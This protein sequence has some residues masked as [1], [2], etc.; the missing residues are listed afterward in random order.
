MKKIYLL[1]TLIF[2]C[3]LSIVCKPD[4]HTIL[5]VPTDGTII[6]MDSE[7]QPKSKVRQ[8]WFDLMHSAGPE[9]NWKFIET[10]NAI[11]QAKTKRALRSNY[12]QSSND[13]EGE[14]VANGR[15]EGIWRERG[16]NNQAGSM[17]AINYFMEEDMLFGRSAGGTLWKG[18][19]TGFNWEVVNQDFNFK[20]DLVEMRYNDQGT[21]RYIAGLNGQ[22]VY[23]DD[24]GNSWLASEIMETSASA[25]VFNFVEV[26]NGMMLI[27][28]KGHSI[29]D[30]TTYYSKDNGTTWQKSTIFDTANRDNIKIARVGNTNDIIA[31]EQINT[32]LTILYKWNH[33]TNTF[34]IINDGSDIGFGNNTKANISAVFVDD[35]I[36]M[37]VRNHEN[38][39]FISDD[40]GLT[41]QYSS[42]LLS[43]PWSVGF[44]VSPSDH[45]K[46]L[47]GDIELYRSIDEGS[48]WSK[49]SDWWE[50]YD[51]VQ[52]KI[53]ADI[54]DIK[55]FVDPEDKPFTIVC[56]HGGISQSY[57]YGKNLSNIGIYS[58]NISQY[59]SVATHPEQDEWIFAGS[60]DQGFQR[61]KIVGDEAVS[62]SQVI[63][64]DYGHIVFSGIDNH[65]WTVYPGGWVTYYTDPISLFSS[66]SY[67]LES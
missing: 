46:I 19:R 29:K 47:Y 44:F 24:G 41:W 49:V 55:E 33:V 36:R 11:T 4:T 7:D 16:S 65:L 15:L 22:A 42:D 17:V 21:I 63:S 12:S 38:K 54:M 37:Y 57:D 20:S 14:I 61:G 39:L 32:D 45:T 62:L 2:V 53:H 25:Q 60:Q 48:S 6:K 35:H 34:E 23:S 18:D 43:T 58:L 40:N 31:I 52:E 10:Q 50:Y 27:L 66:K 28:H 9:Q 51:N 26:I 59:Y 3:M 64:G 1:L 5:P 13:R 8:A 67:E 56:N 30:V